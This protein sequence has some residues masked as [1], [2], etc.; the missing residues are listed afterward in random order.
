MNDKAARLSQV[1]EFFG[2]NPKQ[3]SDKLGENPSNYYQ[4]E[5]GNRRMGKHKSNELIARLNLNPI[6]WETGQGDM[7]MPS[8]IVEVRAVNDDLYEG[9]SLP[10]YAVPVQG[11]FN[12]M[13]DPESN[14]GAAEQI[15]VI[16]RRGENIDRNVVFE[17]D[18]DS[19]APKYSRGTKIRCRLVNPGDWEYLSSG[20]Y[21]ISYGDSFV[22]KRIKDNDLSTRGVLVLHSDNPLVGGSNPIP[23]DQIRHVWKVL[24]IIDSPAD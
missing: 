14:Y 20:V 7:F 15:R 6:W 4:M 8:G 13:S 1:R 21:A 22:V 3:F 24:R 11:S 2:L 5:S 23:A 16:V 18:G 10:Y 19:M 9:I 12:E 17:V